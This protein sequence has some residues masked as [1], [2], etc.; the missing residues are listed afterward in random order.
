MTM[1]SLLC[2][3]TGQCTIDN[4]CKENNGDCDNDDECEGTLKCGKNNCLGDGFLPDD[5]CCYQLEEF[6]PVGPQINQSLAR[7]F[8]GGWTI[9][10]TSPY[11]YQMTDTDVVAIESQ[12]CTENKIMMACRQ[13]FNAF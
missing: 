2:I 13:F 6:Q 11:S 1:A 3:M 8:R 12:N 7:V 10:Y 9:C 4:P 5:D